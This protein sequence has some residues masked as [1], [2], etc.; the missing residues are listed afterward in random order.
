MGYA[1]AL[2]LSLI[3]LSLIVRGK[4]STFFSVCYE[5]MRR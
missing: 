2:N 3:L 1:L 4:P 5:S